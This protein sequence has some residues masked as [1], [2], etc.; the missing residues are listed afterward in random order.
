MK[1]LPAKWVPRLFTLDQKRDRVKC[2]KYDLRPFLRN[3]HNSHRRFSTVD[4][5]WIQHH[6]TEIRER[7]RQWV[8]RES[9]YQISCKVSFSKEYLVQSFL[10]EVKTIKGVHYSAE[11]VVTKFI[12]LG[13][14]FSIPPRLPILFTPACNGGI[15]P[16]LGSYQQSVGT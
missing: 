9:M 7:S 16:I 15:G 8:A 2:S 12:R 11:V 14:Q 4:E 3:L 5:T 6:W 10:E 13:F 1:W